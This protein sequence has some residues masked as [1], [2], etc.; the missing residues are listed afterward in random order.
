MELSAWL[1]SRTARAMVG[2]FAAIFGAVAGCGLLLTRKKQRAGSGGGA[3]AATVCA[4]GPKR[5]TEDL[6]LAWAV[7][8][9]AAFGGIIGF[10]MYTWFDRW[11]YLLVCGSLAAPLLLQPFLAPG[12][13]GESG[14]PLLERHCFKA[15]VW[16]FIFGFIGNWW[17]THY[18]YTVL[19]ASYSMP[20]HDVN[21]VPVA[22]FLATHFYFSLYHVLAAK[23]LRCMA[24]FIHEQG[25]V[26][27]LP[28]RDDLS[29]SGARNP[30]LYPHSC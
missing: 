11:H 12:L 15:N 17:Y 3:F 1:E 4:W 22:M 2:N 20:A 28:A 24:L 19:R 25:F 6:W 26:V 27:M 13:T 9:V 23:A 18:F 5:R 16:V 8:W 7:C 29:S 14:V 10:G 30:H 21:G